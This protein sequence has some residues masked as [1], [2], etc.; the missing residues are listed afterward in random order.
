MPEIFPKHYWLFHSLWHVLLA[1]GY[2]E[3]YAL[4]EFDSNTV[5]RKAKRQKHAKQQPAPAVAEA[6]S[7]TQLER[8]LPSTVG[9]SCYA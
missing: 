2:Y 5:H 1:A 7:A 6:K 9:S 4:I 8:S 3:L